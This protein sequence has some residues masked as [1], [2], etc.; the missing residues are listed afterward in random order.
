MLAVQQN[1]DIHFQDKTKSDRSI[2]ISPTEHKELYQL[3]KRVEDAGFKIE[4]TSSGLSPRS[5]IMFDILKNGQRVESFTVSTMFVGKDKDIEQFTDKLKNF[6]N[7][8]KVPE[9]QKRHENKDQV[10]LPRHS[11]NQNADIKMDQ[12]TLIKIGISSIVSSEVE[13]FPKAIGYPVPPKVSLTD[14][15]KPL[16]DLLYDRNNQGTFKTHSDLQPGDERRSAVLKV[17]NI[18]DSDSL[19]VFV[20]NSSF[21]YTV[22]G[23]GTFQLQ[24]GNYVISNGNDNQSKPVAI[25]EQ[26]IVTS[27]TD[28]YLGS[29]QVISKNDDSTDMVMTFPDRSKAQM[30][31]SL[32]DKDGSLIIASKHDGKS[33]VTT[34]DP[35]RLYDEGK[36]VEESN[37]K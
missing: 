12:D 28:Q 15:D 23:E 22:L 24:V 26:T 19:Q 30:N 3:I 35:Y 6:I 10:V 34:Y 16:D 27:D 13:G 8:N 7:G 2:T 14:I 17:L 37:Q 5:G 25:F 21:K 11:I 1:P 29:S 9:T 32:A 4:T 20:K 31:I 33:T 36:K 18:P